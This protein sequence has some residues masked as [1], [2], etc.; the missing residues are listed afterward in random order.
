LSNVIVN[1][2]KVPIKPPKKSSGTLAVWETMEA[3]A[4]KLIAL[5]ARLDVV[6]QQASGVI[7]ARIDVG[8]ELILTLSSGREII[9]GAARGRDG[10]DGQDSPAPKSIRT[11]VTKHDEQGRVTEFIRETI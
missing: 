6:E 3:L 7:D 1:H 2:A 5:K 10:V 4:S 8:G 11:T 9:A